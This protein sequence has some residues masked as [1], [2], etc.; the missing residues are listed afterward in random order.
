MRL[1]ARRYADGQRL[2]IDG[3][4]LR[5]QV[6]P[7]ARRVCL[8][9]DAA[10]GEAVAVAPSAAALARA[11]TFA[12][13]RQAWL[14]ER[15]A[16]IA[17]P[18]RLAAGEVVTIFG[19]PWRLEPDGRHPR[20]TRAADGGPARLGGCGQGDVDPGLVARLVKREAAAVFAARAAIHCQGLGVARP[21]IFVTDAKTRWGSCSPARPGRGAV[22][23]LSWRL[24][25]A[26]FAVADYVVAHECA[27]LIEANHGP[28]F[29][30]LVRGLAGDERPHRAWLR[31]EGPG[32]HAFGVSR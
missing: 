13:Q 6:N 28:R 21:P 7:R 1:F 15:L 3:V 2:Q 19:A 26:P 10:R 18:R 22:I 4:P 24:A 30:A 5:L 32:L 8:R 16:R 14:A 20:L 25:L 17:P 9:V 11:V 31:A 27:H 12:R 29:W 23:R